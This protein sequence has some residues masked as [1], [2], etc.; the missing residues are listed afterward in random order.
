MS[1]IIQQP[2][3]L[4]FSRNLKKFIISSTKA[5]SFQLSHNGQILDETY[6][7]GAGNLVEIDLRDVVD[8]LLS[9]ALPGAN[10][11]VKEQVDGSAD[12][13]ANID[14]VPVAFRVIK[15][16]VKSLDKTAQEWTDEHWLSW[17]V[18][19]KETLQYMPEWL[20]IYANGNRVV[21]VKGYYGDGSTATGELYAIGGEVLATVDVAWTAVNAALTKQDPVS[22]EVWF[23]DA[24]GTTLSYI[25]R[26]TLRELVENEN[27]FIWINTL[28]GIDSVSFTGWSEDD[29]GLDHLLAE[30]Y[31]DTFDEISIDLNRE[32][33]QSTGYLT[34]PKERWIIDFFYS[35]KR[36]KIHTDGTVSAIVFTGDKTKKSKQDDLINYEF[37]YKYASD[38]LLLNLDRLQVQLPSLQVPVDFFMTQLLSSLPEAQY[39]K[40]LIM[41]VQ[42]PYGVGWQK[43][44]VEKLMLNA[45]AES[46]DN[47]TIKQIDGKLSAT[48]LAVLTA[49]TLQQLKDYIKTIVPV[50]TGGSTDSASGIIDGANLWQAGLTFK[51]SIFNYKMLGQPYSA[52]AR[53]I[54]LDAADPDHDRV[55]VFYLDTFGQFAVKKGVP[56]DNP[57]TPSLTS[58]QLLV[59]SVLIKAGAL[60]PDG[61]EV[62][63]V[64]DDNLEWGTSETHDD[65]VTVDFDSIEDP[66]KGTKCIKVAVNVPDTVAASP[67]H[68]IGERYKGGR[69]FWMDATG[70][71]GLIAAE[72]DT[73]QNVWWSTLAG[74]SVYTTGASGK[75]IGTGAA[76]S[77]LMIG[78]D[79]SV[80]YAVRY[81]DELVI[82]GF[83]DWFMP[84]ELELAEMYFRRYAI[85]NFANKTYWSSTEVTGSDSWKKARCISFDN[86]TPYTRDKNNSYC[87]RA[88]RAFDDTTIASGVSVLTFTPGN[89]ALSF[90]Y[91]Q[92]LPAASGIL[93]LMIR[94][95]L[96][97]QGNTMLQIESILAGTAT[98]NVVISPD[99]ILFGYDPNNDE[100]Q[101]IS[102]PLSKFNAE[103]PTLDSFKISLTGSWTNDIV[104]GLDNI[105]FQIYR[106]RVIAPAVKKSEI[107]IQS[108]AFPK[109]LD[110]DKL[111]APIYGEYPTVKLF[112]INDKGNRIPRDNV[113]E[114]VLTDGKVTSIEYDIPDEITGVIIIS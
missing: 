80:N 8:S 10:D 96:G 53:T 40:S 94:S 4:S 51:S 32:I 1:A 42:N 37:T 73:A 61:I 101:S 5:V 15:G 49:D 79:A 27:I 60:A 76:N 57:V 9:I 64:Y 30:Y 107:P 47:F 18:R 31:D 85:G 21:K 102:I 110:Y 68:Y 97:W 36:F 74:H 83:S 109:I 82:D 41:A 3:S 75:E 28:G 45:L 65:H 103:K 81:C 89:T 90:A 114:Y 93:S 55:D 6:Q 13:I 43:M 71:K 111:Y 17:Q 34:R 26:Y 105:R 48:E 77:A 69:I 92:Q 35:R 29:K 58:A 2:D 86:G 95:S 112:T 22:W 7:P 113:P 44:S 12:L 59:E 84:S 104:L 67:L 56:G 62:E 78:N 16:G 19:D 11:A 33:R 108:A 25:Q 87:V 24:N 50:T 106:G 39:V 100:W 38:D 23:E 46:I 70:K 66:A 14:G 63:Q 20:G 88:I 72:N 52:N 98:G 91:G 99:G 54:T